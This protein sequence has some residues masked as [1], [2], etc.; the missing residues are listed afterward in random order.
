[1]FQ[2]FLTSLHSGDYTYIW[3]GCRLQFWSHT[4]LYRFF[5]KKFK[6]NVKSTCSYLV[7]KNPTSSKLVLAY[8]H[9]NISCS[10][11][12]RKLICKHDSKQS[13]F[14]LIVTTSDCKL[15]HTSLSYKNCKYF[16]FFIKCNFLKKLHP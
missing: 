7:K 3:I 2:H 8:V 4:S 13:E 5:V 6:N 12:L 16:W 1:M 9:S 14:L 15:E 11:L 10:C